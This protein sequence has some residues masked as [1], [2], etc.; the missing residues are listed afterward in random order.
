MGVRLELNQVEFSYDKNRKIIKDISFAVKPGNLLCILGPN[1]S[2]KSTLLRC[3]NGLNR[4]K[5]NSI[6]INGKDINNLKSVEIA[7]LIAYLPQIHNYSFPYT[8]SDIVLMGRAPYIKIFDRPS[9]KDKIIASE[10]METLG[11]LSIKEQLYTKLSGGQLQLVLLAR[12]LAQ[13]PEILLLYEPT[14]HLDLFYQA[15]ILKMIKKLSER[16]ISIIMTSHFPDH[17]IISSGNVALLKEGKIIAFG[18]I[19]EVINEINLKHTYGI[20]VR[21]IHVGN[22]INRDLCIPML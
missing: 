22:G 10:A 11:I 6:F 12:A 19:T 16:G 9:K 4:I 7:R 1:G 8:V 13:K 5:D 3:I 15:K 21:I 14:A 2:G 20:E 18:H 17:A